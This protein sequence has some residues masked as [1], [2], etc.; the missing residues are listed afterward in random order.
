M[1]LSLTVSIRCQARQQYS[2]ETDVNEWG[3]I[4][5]VL[6]SGKM[7]TNNVCVWGYYCWNAG[8][9]KGLHNKRPIVFFAVV[10]VGSFP[11]PET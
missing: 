1:A 6:Y 5:L 9:V 3:D 8:T 7:S 11:L 2:F 10:I 4:V